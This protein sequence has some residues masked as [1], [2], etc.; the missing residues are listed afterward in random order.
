MFAGYV[1]IHNIANKNGVNSLFFSFHS[2]VI[3]ICILSN[4]NPNCN[5]KQ[6]QMQQQLKKDIEVVYEMN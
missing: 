3:Q 4:A 6:L 1:K 2:Q 5:W